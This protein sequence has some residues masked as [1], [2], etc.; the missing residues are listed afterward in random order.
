MQLL[1]FR[2][3]LP[4]LEFVTSPQA[5]FDSVKEDY[6]ELAESGFFATEAQDGFFIY[7]I[8][9]NAKL[10]TGIIAMIDM[11]KHNSRTFKPKADAFAEAA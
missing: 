11:A 6:I 1:P 9:K 2:A 5:F 10:Y 3:T 7:Q 4:R 8:E